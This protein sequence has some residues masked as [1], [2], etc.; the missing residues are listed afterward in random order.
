MLKS[1]SSDSFTRLRTD[2]HSAATSRRSRSTRI[3][4]KGCV[5][6]SRPAIE[7][8]SIGSTFTAP[9]AAM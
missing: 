7:S 6:P 1:Y 2:S 9:V 4:V 8:L 5:A 3:A